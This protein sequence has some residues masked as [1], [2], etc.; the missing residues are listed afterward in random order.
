MNDLLIFRK[1]ILC[2]IMIAACLIAPHLAFALSPEE[3]LVIANKNIADSL[4]LADFYMQKRKIPKTHLLALKSVSQETCSR[5]EYEDNILTPLKNC[6]RQL[7][8]QNQPIRCL[9]VMFGL[10]LKIEAQTGLNTRQIKHLK[11]IQDIIIRE[12]ADTGEKAV[13]KQKTLKK[14]IKELKSEINTIQSQTN[15]ASLD[16]EIALVLAKDY[17]LAGWLA[18]PYYLG[19]R[20]R[21]QVIEQKEVLMVSRLD[22]PSP[23]IVKRII[24]DSLFVENTGLKGTAYF[25]A[26]WPKAKQGKLSGYT[27]YDNALHLAAENLRDKQLFPVILDDREQLFQP[28]ECPQAA[29]YCGWYS[30]ADYVDAFAWQKGAVGY[31]IASAECVTLK[32]KNSRV[33]CKMMLDKGVAATIGP[34]SEPYVQAFPMPNIFFKF[35]TEGYL[36]LAECYILSLPYLSWQMVLIGD[37]LYQPFKI[38]P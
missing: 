31:H 33:W 34:T 2:W 14:K 38:R 28:Q 17:P 1:R 16:S 15:R 18:N 4:D 22:G 32:K 8:K 24:L 25:D 29:L 30:L 5:K 20:N 9:V 35:L 23:A 10:P 27:L 37:P 36:S 3:I 21:K 26:R 11:K 12:L 13:Q 7:D 19:F 6:L